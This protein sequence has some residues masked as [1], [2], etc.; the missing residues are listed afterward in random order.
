MGEGVG[1]VWNIV[2][3]RWM[4]KDDVRKMGFW[5]QKNMKCV[6]GSLR[7]MCR[8]LQVSSL[9]HRQKTGYY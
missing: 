4:S 9:N 5:L 3:Y 8:T 7:I 1:T 6:A 2:I